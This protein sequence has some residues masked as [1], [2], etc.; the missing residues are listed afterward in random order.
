MNALTQQEIKVSLG[1]GLVLLIGGINSYFTFS[2]SM[3][4]SSI[5]ISVV[6][7]AIATIKFGIETHIRLLYDQNE[8]IIAA[9]ERIA[10]ERDQ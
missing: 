5:A 6:P 10:K 7:L 1:I 3:G 4:L 9:L 2:Q 8:R